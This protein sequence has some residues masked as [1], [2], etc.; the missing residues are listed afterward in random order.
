MHLFHWQYCALIGIFLAP[1][2]QASDETIPQTNRPA[3]FSGAA[4]LYTIQVRATPTTVRVEEPITLTVKIVSQQPGPWKYPPQRDKLKLFA[5]S[6]EQEFF[7]EPLPEEDRFLAGEKAWEFS[8]RLLPRSE[9]VTKIPEP[10]FVYYRT[11]DPQDFAVAEGARSLG[12]TV[13]PRAP[14]VVTGPSAVRERLEQIAEGDHLLAQDP[15]GALWWT[16]VVGGL[17]LP[18]MCCAAFYI[19]WRKAFPQAAERVRRRRSRALKTAVK[20]LQRLGRAAPPD[21]VRAVVLDYLRAHLH[22]IPGEPTPDEVQAVLK[23][24]GISMDLMEKCVALL[25]A[26]D[27]ARF[28]ALAP[29]ADDGLALSASELLKSLEGELCAPSR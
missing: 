4:G 28:V 27:T 21:Q 17:V 26:C 14:L 6:L 5:A 7:V 2:W 25:T 19:G 12:L 1:L 18:P 13:K 29:A 15:S 22:L 23:P 10:E 3:N 24:Q 9:R 11:A 8:W 20:Q 16:L